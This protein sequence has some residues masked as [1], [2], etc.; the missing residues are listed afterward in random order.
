M[1]RIVLEWTI[2]ACALLPLFYY[3]IVIYSGWRYF[4]H[5]MKTNE[6]FTPPVSILKP[7][8]GVEPESYANFSSFCRLDYPACEILFGVN[9]ADDPVVPVIR[10]L[11]QDFPKQH[12]RLLIGSPDGGSNDK[13]RKLRRL[14]R[15]AQ[16]GILVISDSDIRVQPDY[17]RAVVEPFQ[18]PQVGAV[19][20]LYCLRAEPRLGPELEAIGL[21][22]DFLPS[23]LAA[24]QLEGVKFAL[25]ATMATRVETLAE[26]G[27]FEVIADSLMDDFELG[28]RIAAK[29]YQVRLLPYTVSTI[30]ASEGAFGF[31]RHQLRSAVG[32]RHSRPWGH[33]GRLLT[34]GLPWAMAAAIVDSSGMATAAF[35]GSYLVLRLAMAWTVG[36]WGLKDPLLRRKWWLVPLWDAAAFAI[37]AASFVQN[38]VR[39]C[40]TEFYVRKGKLIPTTSR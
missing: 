9:E 38:R 30:P 25:G 20:C 7:V 26:I 12:I 29:G 14:A 2:S 23:V 36:V 22:S 15:E 33:F 21:A 34:Q 1:L 37:W 19:T 32:I 11:M 40:G 17:L 10:K 13:V 27:G 28:N 5:P 31:F 35:L 3:L 16:Y 24:R 18:D 4:R 8:R 39:W 6:G